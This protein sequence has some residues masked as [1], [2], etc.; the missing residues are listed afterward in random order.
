MK[1]KRGEE[2]ENEVGWGEIGLEGEGVRES[3]RLIK[4]RSRSQ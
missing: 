1:M 2:Q 4:R 3:Y